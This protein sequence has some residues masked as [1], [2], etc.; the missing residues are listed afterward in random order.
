MHFKT[1]RF[2]KVYII[3][4]ITIFISFF[5]PDLGPN[6]AI[7]ELPLS[8]RVDEEG[9]RY[10]S[11]EQTQS[12]ILIDGSLDDQDWE[13]AT[14]QKHFLQREPVYGQESSEE[15]QVALLKDEDNLYLGIKCY[16]SSS[17]EIIANEMR[18]DARI[19]DDDFFEIIFDTF[20]DQRNG[21]YFVINPNGVKRD[22]TLGDE[23]KS[24]NPNWDGIWDCE[25]QISDEGWFAEIAIP[26]KTLRFDSKSD[27]SWGVNFA[28]MI[29]RKN[30]HVFWQLISRD[31]GRGG[32][33]RLSQ[34]GDLRGLSNLQSGG[35]IDFLPYIMGGLSKDIEVNSTYSQVKEIGLD[36]T[37]SITSNINLKL[38]WNTDFAQVESDQERVNLT[39]FSLYYP[40]KREFFLDGAEIFNFGGTRMGGRGGGDGSTGLNLFYSRRIGILEGHQQ[41]IIGG[42]KLLGKV[43]SFQFGLLNMLT[44]DFEAIEEDEDTEEDVNVK[45]RG[46]NYSVFRLK[47][48]IFKRS[49]I[50]VM[51]L[52]KH[53]TNSQYYN[54]SGGVDA[55][56]PL[57]ENFTVS[58]NIA[59]TT[60]LSTKVLG[61][62]D[63]NLAG[64]LALEYKS[65]LMDLK[66]SHLSIQENF[67][68]E[69]GFI[70]RT[71]IRKTSAEVEYSPRPKSSSAIRQYHYEIQYDYLTNQQ[72]RL[73]ENDV[74]ASVRLDL[75]NSS[76]IGAGFNYKS[77]FIDELWEVRENLFI[78]INIYQGWETYAFVM[79]D[80]SKDIST[81]TFA[82]Y[83]DYYTGKGLGMRS[84]LIF[85]N[86]SR[87]R[88]DV[89]FSYDNVQLPD[90]AFDIRTLG[91]RIYY[92]LS[93]NL[94]IKA[95]LQWKDDKKANDGNRIALSNI[96]FRWIYRPGSDIYLV[97]NEGWNVGL[98]GNQMTNRS[99]LLKFT[100]FWRN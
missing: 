47:K 26:W 14:F 73:L 27:S 15:T 72:N 74:S 33:F 88:A 10:I 87:F 1:K 90:G 98:L 36:A 65:D 69:L 56:F 51:L 20:H 84:T 67:N 50:G 89:D 9:N 13:Q 100:Y 52:N 68:A 91:C 39:R 31:A 60:D 62:N 44:E 70:R 99:I 53:H 6:L 81:R 79:T 34:A 92:F 12:D 83:G 71:D 35:T 42:M 7:A 75:Q 77:E 93:T 97:Y 41:P 38:S 3:I 57:T 58:G 85:K 63:K 82:G 2:I 95:Y 19:D 78:P 21:Y 17:S 22:A 45:Y 86:I 32:L 23:G 4:L 28:R 76:R 61:I 40:E 24:Y 54:R 30:E 18:R 59:A 48:D 66:L 8:A 43:G 80:E 94:Y 96:L 25:T 37:F 5:L 55:I 49:S 11:I 29:R 64:T 46:A 16:D